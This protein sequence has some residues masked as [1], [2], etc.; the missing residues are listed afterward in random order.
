MDTYYRFL[1]RTTDIRTSDKAESIQILQQEN[2]KVRVSIGKLSEKGNETLLF[3]NT[4]DPDIT[5][6]IRLF[7]GKGNDSVKIDIPDSEIK[8]R[9]VGGEGQKTYDVKAS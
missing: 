2:N 5:K 6:E 3:D 7:I 1:Y 9:I 8:F 4:F